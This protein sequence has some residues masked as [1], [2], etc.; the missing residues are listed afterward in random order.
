M[1]WETNGTPQGRDWQDKRP[2]SGGR[3]LLLH[4]ACPRL[5][6]RWGDSEPIDVDGTILH[7]VCPMVLDMD[8]DRN[9]TQYCAVV[10]VV[11]EEGHLGSEWTGTLLPGPSGPLHEK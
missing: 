4:G 2:A 3:C 1:P 5:S 10:V 6:R 11:V 9:I 7:Y 8:G